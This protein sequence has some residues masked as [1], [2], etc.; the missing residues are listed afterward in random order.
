MTAHERALPSEGVFISLSFPWVLPRAIM[1]KDHRKC[2]VKNK[3][4]EKAK[5]GVPPPL[6]YGIL[7]AG[8]WPGDVQFCIASPK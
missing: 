1:K 6:L 5:K 7:S 4:Q 3:P 2:E 8:G